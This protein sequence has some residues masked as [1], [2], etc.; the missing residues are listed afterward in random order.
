[1][2]GHCVGQLNPLTLEVVVNLL[3]S[4]LDHGVQKHVRAGA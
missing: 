3:L 4:K 1:M 2:L